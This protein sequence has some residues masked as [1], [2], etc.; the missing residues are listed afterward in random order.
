ML[1]VFLFIVR[2]DD[3]IVQGGNTEFSQY[4]GK[5]MVD[6][7]LKCRLGVLKSEGREYKLVEAQRT[8]E[9]RPRNVRVLDR[10]LSER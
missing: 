10:D 2:I 5:D 8:S 1:R 7:I 9:R 4:G 3:D 6:Q